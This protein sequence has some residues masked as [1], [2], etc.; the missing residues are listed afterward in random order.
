VVNPRRRYVVSTSTSSFTSPVHSGGNLETASHVHVWTTY[1]TYAYYMVVVVC[2]CVEWCVPARDSR[3]VWCI[4]DT[5]AFWRG[6]A[7]LCARVCWSR[8]ICT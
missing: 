5:P 8:R 2:G 3:E 1:Y 6:A 4:C 7:G